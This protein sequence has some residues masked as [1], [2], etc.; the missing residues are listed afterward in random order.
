MYS[1]ELP[2]TSAMPEHTRSLINNN[3]SKHLWR[4][5]HMLGA[6]DFIYMDSFNAHNNPMRK[7]L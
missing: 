7:V 3:E 1:Y 6:K 5:Y 2:I 4:A